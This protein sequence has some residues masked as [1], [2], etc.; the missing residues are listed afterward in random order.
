MLA[1]TFLVF[2]FAFPTLCTLAEM[3]PQKFSGNTKLVWNLWNFFS[4]VLTV[5]CM[6][7]H[8]YTNNAFKV[9]FFFFFYKYGNYLRK[10]GR[11][12]RTFLIQPWHRAITF[13]ELPH[14]PDCSFSCSL[15]PEWF[16]VCQAWCGFVSCLYPRPQYTNAAG[17]AQQSIWRHSQ[18]IIGDKLT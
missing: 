6:H 17:Q 4:P 10:L 15:L 9:T 8:K 11:F 5:Q 14:S 7:Y 2:I 13:G 3:T 16:Q 18:L 12:P 1:I